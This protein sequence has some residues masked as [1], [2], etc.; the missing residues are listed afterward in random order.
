[1]WRLAFFLTLFAT[2]QLFYGS[3]K[4]TWV[5]RLVIDQA[6]VQTAAWLINTLDPAIGVQSSGSRLRAP[7]GGINV[8]NGCEGTDVAFLMIAAMLVAPQSWRARVAGLLV[9]TALVFVL[10]QARVV[11]LFYAFRTDKA[12]FDTLHGI[13]APLLLIIG[14]AAFFMIWLHRH[15]AEPAIPAPAQPA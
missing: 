15:A 9:G 6:T 11:T 2:L 3:A 8:L 14:A 10:N 13:V 4:G 1:M 12:L 5:E 7:G